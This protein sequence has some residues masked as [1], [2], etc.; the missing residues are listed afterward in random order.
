[1]QYLPAV[2]WEDACLHSPLPL[3]YPFYFPSC[4][5]RSLPHL[6]SF[7]H[8]PTPPPY[9]FFS[10]PNSPPMPPYFF[11]FLPLTPLSTLTSSLFTTFPTFI[12][13][14]L[15]PS[16]YSFTSPP[17]HTPYLLLLPTPI[18]F[19]N[20]LPSLLLTLSFPLVPPLPTSP[21]SYFPVLHPYYP[22]PYLI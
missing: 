15:P 7:L 19:S 13:S 18:S 16:P 5:L 3:P 21:M 9:R 1:M 2:P 12:S 14:L 20:S 4:H 10:L 8:P 11:S 6:F 17:A 22:F